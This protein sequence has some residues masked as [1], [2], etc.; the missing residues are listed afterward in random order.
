VPVELLAG[1]LSVGLLVNVVLLVW[2]S[3]SDRVS[4]RFPHRS[5][6]T[7][8]TPSSRT[9]AAD[10]STLRRRALL[11]GDR[12]A[13]GSG[14]AGPPHVS[15]E[16][17][18]E[19]LPPSLADFLSQAAPIA[20]P[21]GRHGFVT[22]PA[23]ADR[24][25]QLPAAAGGPTRLTRLP[26]TPLATASAESGIAVD[27]LTGLEGPAG[28]T[29]IVEIENARLL[30]YRRPVTVVMT[31]VEGL[32]HLAERVGDAPVERLLPVIA[33][34]FRREARASDWVA[35]VGPSRFAVLLAETDE[36]QAVHYVER[37]R[38]V[39][40][41]WLASS[42]VPLRLAV[43]WSAPSSSSDLEFA[44]RRAEERMHS[45]RR[46]PGKTAQQSRTSTIRPTPS[47]TVHSSFD[48]GPT[49]GRNT[50]S[51]AETGRVM[52]ASEAETSGLSGEADPGAKYEGETADSAI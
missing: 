5:H 46:S 7:H 9:V 1:V 32:R 31:E 45:D 28:W 14:S 12:G 44:L 19:T 18:S 17:C 3:R 21:A 41:P 24:E 22:S 10:A 29:R 33:E 48:E 35:R 27:S 6:G 23:G 39:C 13:A 36:I 11:A 42:A 40:E 30:R 25:L 43:G 20:P 26:L 16:P 15:R 50:V 2:A 52:S 38:I 47:L 51:P 8:A 34:A 4:F 37:I 49:A